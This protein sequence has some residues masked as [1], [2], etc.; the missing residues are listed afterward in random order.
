MKKPEETKEE[1]RE[2][3]IAHNKKHWI[4]IGEVE[5]L[6]EETPYRSLHSV[7]ECSDAP[8]NYLFR[9]RTINCMYSI[10]PSY[11]QVGFVNP[12]ITDKEISAITFLVMLI[13]CSIEYGRNMIKP[14]SKNKIRLKGMTNWLEYNDD[15]LNGKINLEELNK[16][17]ST[18]NI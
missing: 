6:K 5:E 10:A 4:C 3:V 8:N 16:I 2:R 17:Y 14:C 13:S 18:I 11:Y 15:Y 9:H 1:Y 12:F 7:I